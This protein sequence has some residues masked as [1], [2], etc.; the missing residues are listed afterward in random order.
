VDVC[1][2]SL[3]WHVCSGALGAQPSTRTL[4]GLIFYYYNYCVLLASLALL[5]AVP[6][7]LDVCL[8]FCCCIEIDTSDGA[9]MP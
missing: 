1:H 9:M 8:F 3:A 2:L 6:A 4:Y 7:A 5:P